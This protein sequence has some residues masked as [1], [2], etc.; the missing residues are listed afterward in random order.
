MGGYERQPAAWALDGI[1][2]DF[3]GK[4]LPPDWERFA[5]R[6]TVQPARDGHYLAAD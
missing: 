6:V 1:P 3:N 5:P 4:L 2:Q